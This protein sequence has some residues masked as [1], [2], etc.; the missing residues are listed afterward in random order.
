MNRFLQQALA[1]IAA[2]SMAG[3]ISL[4]QETPEK[5]AQETPEKQVYMAA[6]AHFDTQ[7]RWNVRQSIGEFLPN[8]LYQNFALMEQ[9]PDYKFSFEGAVKHYW[10]KEY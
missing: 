3:G 7:W 8:T 2:L 6:N 10:T 9:Y 4:A 1:A 5:L